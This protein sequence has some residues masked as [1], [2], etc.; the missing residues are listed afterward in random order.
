MITSVLVADKAR[1]L[2]T[3]TILDLESC[4]GATCPCRT[5]HPPP[6]SA[7]SVTPVAASSHGWRSHHRMMPR[8]NDTTSKPGLSRGPWHQRL[9]PSPPPC[10]V[11][12]SPLTIWRLLE[13]RRSHELGGHTVTLQLSPGTGR[14]A[15][16]RHCPTFWDCGTGAFAVGKKKSS[17]EIKCGWGETFK[18]ELSFIFLF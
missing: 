10:P 8:R 17:F 18:Q 7:S 9:R 6:P 3:G 15:Q 4:I 2:W 11:L 5:L 16:R 13:D 14:P 12:L 1:R